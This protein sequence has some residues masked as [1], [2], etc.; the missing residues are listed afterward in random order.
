MPLRKRRPGELVIEQ[1]N[2]SAIVRGLLE[3]AAIC[4][5]GIDWP[6]ACHLAAFIDEETV[7]AATVE[8]MIDAAVLRAIY[9]SELRRGK[10]VGAK[11]LSA[12]RKAAHTRGARTLF[13]IERQERGFFSHQGFERV[14]ME[15]LVRGVEGTPTADLLAA[16]PQA[17]AGMFAFKLD[18]SA[19]GM[20]Q[21]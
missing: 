6:A 14:A 10:A 3:R 2:D 1:T 21:R 13:A 11:L 18:I 15:E 4:V 17:I 12:A 8:C 19:D 9:V 20:I 5:G 16:H 7:G